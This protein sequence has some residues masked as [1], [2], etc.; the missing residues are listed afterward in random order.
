MPK[1]ATY[2]IGWAIAIQL[3]VM[4]MSWVI[5]QLGILFGMIPF[6]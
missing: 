1:F 4:T 5:D 2:F 6:F 3:T